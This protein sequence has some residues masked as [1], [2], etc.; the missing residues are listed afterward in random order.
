MSP[1]ISRSR[2]GH[3]YA[4]GSNGLTLGSEY[5]FALGSGRMASLFVDALFGE[6]GNNAVLGGVRFYFGQRDKTLIDRHRQDDPA[7]DTWMNPGGL[8]NASTLPSLANTTSSTQ[9]YSC[10]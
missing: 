3:L 6:G 4:F 1:T 5:G 7:V 9:N 10:P 2:F 8:A